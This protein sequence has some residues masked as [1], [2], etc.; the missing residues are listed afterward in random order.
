MPAWSDRRVYWD[1]KSSTQLYVVNPIAVRLLHSLRHLNYHHLLYFWTVAR[2]GSIVEAA[3]D[4]HLTPQT[5]S[6]QIKQLEHA[7][8]E[9]LFRRSGRG[10]TLTDAGRL[11]FHYADDI[12]TTGI[13]LAQQ[14]RNETAALPASLG[15]G[16]VSSIPK[17]IA[18]RIL[19]P[20]L[21]LDQPTRII[22]VEGPL[23]K[24]LGELAV[25]KLD[26][27]VSDHAIPPGLSI[28]AFNHRL[29][30]SPIGMFAAA[31]S[32]RGYSKKFPESLDGAP[33][34]LP[35]QSNPVRR[36]LDDW[37]QLVGVEPRV[38]A[39][40]EDSALLKAFGQEGVGVFPAPVAI[41]AEIERMYHAR[42]IGM[43]DGLQESYFAISSERRIKHPA[44]LEVSEAAR[45]ILGKE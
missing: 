22:C 36:G 23:E 31:R 15:V 26:L 19:R 6:G 3:Q 13:E 34:L 37:F 38:V 43:V 29:G 11:V 33:V 28:K 1:E 7:V 39:E 10:L 42:C 30:S 35:V 12:F 4:L 9:Q 45:S 27:V 44:V 41:Q 25:H 21:E 20:A 24:L 32:A 8:G 17:L 18:H 5:I 2:E 14:V 40:F 16:V